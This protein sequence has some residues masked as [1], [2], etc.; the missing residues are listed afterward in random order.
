MKLQAVELQLFKKQTR[1]QLF[2]RE[3]HAF[4]AASGTDAFHVSGTS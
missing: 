4:Q 3:F 1:T 2:F